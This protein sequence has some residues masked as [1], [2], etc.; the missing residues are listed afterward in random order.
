M[1]PSDDAIDWSAAHS[2]NL[3]YMRAAGL[4]TMG[5]G[6]LFSMVGI[7]GG[8]VILG[9]TQQIAPAAAAAVS[10]VVAGFVASRRGRKV[11][12]GE[13]LVI[14]G[15]LTRKGRQPVGKPG[16]KKPKERLLLVVEV[17]RA[18]RLKHDD[19]LLDEPEM[20][21]A[22]TVVAR[23]PLYERVEA[24]ETLGLLCLS[25]GEAIAR[26]DD[27]PLQRPGV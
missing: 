10:G 5:L 13:P 22:R 16:K 9:L 27:F 12:Q 18:R 26:L 1:I 17:R 7:I 21:G 24:G 19:D 11:L 8:G 15:V 4:A 3:R 20:I 2:A 23:A 14:E 6:T 25:S